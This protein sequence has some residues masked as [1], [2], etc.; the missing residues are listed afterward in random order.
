[1]IMQG[2]RRLV[3]L[4][5]VAA[6]ALAP[7]VPAAAAPLGDV[8]PLNLGSLG[9]WYSGASGLNDRDQ[10]VG[11]YTNTSDMSKRLAFVWN[12]GKLTPLMRVLARRLTIRAMP[13]PVR[14]PPVTRPLRLSLI[15]ISEPTR[16]GMI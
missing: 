1:M 16:L 14:R 15:H 13:S 2:M 12:R 11:Y 7:A 10:V 9:D 5:A 6:V 4:L 8:S 3:I